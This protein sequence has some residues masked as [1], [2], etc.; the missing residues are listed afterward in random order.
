M[1]IFFSLGISRTI[2]SEDDD[3]LC[4]RGATNALAHE[5]IEAETATVLNFIVHNQDSNDHVLVV[6]KSAV[7][8]TVIGGGE[9]RE[10]SSGRR[11]CEE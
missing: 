5:S 8:L 3:V 10:E 1:E 9:E 6:F 11:E 4:V 7:S 2:L